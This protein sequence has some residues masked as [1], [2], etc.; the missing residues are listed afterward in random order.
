ME[1]LKIDIKG[2]WIFAPLKGRPLKHT[3]EED[4]RQ[5]FICRLVN[6][7]GY[8]LGQMAQELTTTESCRGTG[9]ARADIVIWPSSEA[10]NNSERAVIVVECKA[11]YVDIDE[12]AYFQGFNYASWMHAKYLVLTNLKETKCYILN[13]K[14]L[15]QTFFNLDEIN[16][17]PKAEQVRNI[18]NNKVLSFSVPK[19]LLPRD[20]EV[21]KLYAELNSNQFLNLVGVGGSGKS[22]LTFLMKQKYEDK[23]NASA[24]VVVNNNIKDDIVS[25]LST[26]LKLK[27][28]E[29]EKNIDV[30]YRK[31]IEHLEENYS[32]G[33]NLLVIDINETSDKKANEKFVQDLID[34]SLSTNKIYPDKWKIL[35]LSREKIGDFD[36]CINLNENIDIDFLKRLFLSKAGHRYEKFHEIDALME[37][38]KFSPLLAEHLG[39]YLCNIPKTKTLE[40]IEGILYN[41]NMK[42][43]GINAK[44]RSDA[45]PKTIV[46]FLQNL[47]KYQEFSDAEQKLL[48]HFVLWPSDYLC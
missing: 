18:R 21:D 20:K 33:N 6:E 8:S 39:I 2:D 4:V 24:Y 30:R 32:I 17:I 43:G 47:I 5:K 42:R 10:K 25:Q 13:E 23:F 11:E 29:S 3:P 19:G 37:V 36:C 35:I 40:E 15:P 31:I 14:Y 16:D 45:D 7:Y 28:D 26:T 38:I 22:S 9:K 34:N 44:N 46:Y 1:E 12:K 27:F 41:T 48:R